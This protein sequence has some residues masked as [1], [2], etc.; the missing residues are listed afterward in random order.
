M[1][2]TKTTSQNIAL[3]VGPTPATGHQT[4]TSAP[5]PLW[6]LSACDWSWSNPKQ[7]VLH[8]GYLAA[9]ERVTLDPPEVTLNFSYYVTSA[10]NE[11]ILGFN[12]N[13]T[14]SALKYFLNKTEDEKNYFIFIAPEG[15][16][17]F[18]LSGADTDI[19]IIGVGNG[20]LNSYSLEAAVGDFPTVSVG[21]Q[22]LN[23]KTYTGGYLQDIPAVNP[24]TGLEIT[25]RKFTISTISGRSVE[26]VLR[27]GDITVDLSTAG[28]I[29]YDYS[30]ASVQSISMSFDLNRAPLNE[31]G[32]KFSTSREMT[33]PINVNFEATML[34]KGLN[35]GSLAQFLC[36]SGLYNINVTF[37]NPSCSGDGAQAFGF[38][39][40][41]VSLE[42]QSSST[43]A[44]A[45]A[46]TITTT[47]LG[48]IGGT[49]DL[50]NGFFLSGVYV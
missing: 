1:A 25:G 50:T 45:E 30:T 40:K 19:G 32:K 23:F 29:F 48:Q 47:W 17:A 9:R 21:V 14:E 7:D 8:Y 49:G 34:A 22:G 42:G 46:Q 2:R 16:D 39:L 13:G 11:D 43:S 38:S 4:G 28:G 18:G 27:P 37:K 12:T 3:L 24:T 6:A 5:E 26:N 10:V 41:N 36:Q 15:A 35:T 44:G 33:F 31:L 20:F